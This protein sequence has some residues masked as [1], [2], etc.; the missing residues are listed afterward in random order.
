[1]SSK[2][3][4]HAIEVIPAAFLAFTLE[5]PGLHFP[6]VST[7]TK[8][9]PELSPLT[10]R[11]KR[12]FHASAVISCLCSTRVA[13]ISKVDAPGRSGLETTRDNEIIPFEWPHAMILFTRLQV[14]TVTSLSSG[15]EVLLQT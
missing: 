4:E 3:Q 7:Q 5:I 9:H 2:F 8:R 15:D 14:T 6:E 12:S 1:M 10:N 13:N 11:L